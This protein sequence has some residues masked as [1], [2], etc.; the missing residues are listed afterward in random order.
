MKSNALRCFDNMPEGQKDNSNL[1]FNIKGVVAEDLQLGPEGLHCLE[2]QGEKTG[3]QT[4]Q[5]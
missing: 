3:L 1:F 5:S 4:N 2:N